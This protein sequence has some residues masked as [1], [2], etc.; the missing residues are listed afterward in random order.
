M[1]SQSTYEELFSC[2]SRCAVCSSAERQL[3]WG[4]VDGFFHCFLKDRE[5]LTC[6]L[7]ETRDSE[8]PQQSHSR[9]HCPRPDTW[10]QGLPSRG[11]FHT[12]APGRTD[13][14]K[15]VSAKGSGLTSYSTEDSSRGR[16]GACSLRGRRVDTQPRVI[17]C[18]PLCSPGRRPCCSQRACRPER[19]RGRAPEPLGFCAM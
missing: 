13:E 19:V 15:A 16:E 14:R 7:P 17:P 4:L 6:S 5:L 8:R 2:S 10:L 9:G 3:A 18:L 12:V 1:H 11:P